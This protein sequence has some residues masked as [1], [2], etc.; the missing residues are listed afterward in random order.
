MSTTTTPVGQSDRS[1]LSEEQY[2]ASFGAL[3]GGNPVI[4][5]RSAGALAP[6]DGCVSC[7][8][9]TRARSAAAS[10]LLALTKSE[11]LLEAEVIDLRAELTLTREALARALAGGL[12]EPH[13]SSSTSADSILLGNGNDI[14]GGLPDAIFEGDGVIP[15][16]CVAECSPHAGGVLCVTSLPPFFNSTNTTTSTKNSVIVVASGGADGIVAFSSPPHVFTTA[17]VVLRAPVLCVAARPW[18][19]NSQ[20]RRQIAASTIDG[21]LSLISFNLDGDS[22][23]SNITFETQAHAGVTPRIAWCQDGS[24]LASGSADGSVVLWKIGGDID[25]DSSNLSNGRGDDADGILTRIQGIWFASGGVTALTWVCEQ[26]NPTLRVDALAVTVRSASVLYYIRILR[27]LDAINIAQRIAR[28]TRGETCS[29]NNYTAVLIHR[30]PL[31]EDAPRGDVSWPTL[32]AQ[33]ARSNEGGGLAMMMLGGSVDDVSIPP[34][35]ASLLGPLIRGDA[36]FP[37][38]GPPSSLVSGGISATRVGFSIE[39]ISAAPAYFS[40]SSSSSSSSS[41]NNTLGI[42]PLFAVADD[43]GSIRIS[44]WGCS[45]RGST[46][47]RIGAGGAARAGGPTTRIAW[48]SRHRC[49]VDDDVDDV[50]GEGKDPYYLAITG[51]NA[52]AIRI[53]SVAAGRDTL[54]LE[55]HNAAVKDIIFSSFCKDKQQQLISASFDKK[56]CVW[57]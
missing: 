31:S 29:T 50:H 13:Y 27:G 7:A 28:I 47:R 43:A 46:L 41:S 26:V 21:R 15:R 4:H 11:E 57:E 38:P 10:Q 30:A 54:M 12:G 6:V 55:G 40:G 19:N 56:V 5:S 44:R 2:L 16:T 20:Q 37:T 24:V 35:D 34:A 48:L 32:L 17:R 1:Q 25:G 45:G 22:A 8:R 23:S 51:G 33:L 3:P 18:I 42:V 9:L 14:Y 52:N 39:E 53:I 36:A 49:D